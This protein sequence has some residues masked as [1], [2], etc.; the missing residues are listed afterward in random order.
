MLIM[1]MIMNNLNINQLLVFLGVVAI[2]NG[3]SIYN[4]ACL[5]IEER[6]V[7]TT[8]LLS[9]SALALFL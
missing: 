3:Y 4:S 7:Y 9:E 1:K 6:F 5:S 2:A 8:S